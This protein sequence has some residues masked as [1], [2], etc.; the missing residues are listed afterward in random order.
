MPVIETRNLVKIYG[1]LRKKIKALDKLSIGVEEGSCVGLLGPNGAGKTTT[2]KILCG[3]L[4]PTEGEAYIKN[5]NVTKKPDKALKY[6]GAIVGE[7]QIYP[8]LTPKE[9]LT[10][11][12][13]LRG[14]SGKTL[15]SRIQEVLRI[16][17]LE[18][19]AD[20]RVGKF[21]HGMKQR[22]LLAQAMLHDPEIFLL[23]EPL[24]GLD[25]KGIAEMR[26]LIINLKNEG[27][28]ILF[29]SHILSEVQQICDEVALIDKGKLLLFDR[30]DRLRV[31]REYVRVDIRSLDPI[32]D[33]I[34]RKIKEAEYVVSVQRRGEK[35]FIVDINGDDKTVATLV[36][37]IVKDIGLKLVSFSPAES[38][39]EDVYLK[40]IGEGDVE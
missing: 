2:I 20:M 14:M 4:K 8:E 19:W 34:L 15:V 25:P 3:L 36:D 7:P 30:I 6:I 16:V 11:M 18:E 22:L 12:G 32:R 38:I 9:F 39:L 24:I 26:D 28:T 21:S 40:L 29:S 31:G 23:D 35:E 17:G 13:K 10:Y 27:R 33:E 1:G 5:I 37:F